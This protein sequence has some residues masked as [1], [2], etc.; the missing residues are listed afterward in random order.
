MPECIENVTSFFTVAVN[1]LEP[2]YLWFLA[3]TLIDCI[4]GQGYITVMRALVAQPA[5]LSG[6]AFAK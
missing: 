5:E 3:K 2:Y 1:E 4:L 6:L